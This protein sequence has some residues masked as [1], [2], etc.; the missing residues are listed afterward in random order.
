MKNNMKK[1]VLLICFCFLSSFHSNA[2]IAKNPEDISPLLIG[3]KIPKSKLKDE[4][5]N[6]VILNDLLKEIYILIMTTLDIFLYFL[7]ALFFYI[8]AFA[9]LIPRDWWWELRFPFEN[10]FIVL[11]CISAIQIQ[12]TKV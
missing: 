4:K 1:S 7:I 3:E 11:R 10:V 6:T 5:G 12:I 9:F 8:I 2:Q